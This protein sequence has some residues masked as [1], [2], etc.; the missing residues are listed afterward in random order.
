MAVEDKKVPGAQGSHFWPNVFDP[1]RDFGH[2][3]SNFFSPSADAS[4]SKDTYEIS[5]ELPGVE[6]KDIDISIHDNVLTIMGEKKFEQEKK[7]K[8]YYFSERRY[9]SFQR[10]FRLPP[11]IQQNDIDAHFKNGVLTVKIP[12]MLEQEP[13]RQKIDIRT[14]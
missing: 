5:M 8:D 2:A 11:G 14:E 13:E 12:K 9:G 6:E 3:V 4:N 1:L 7:E 10:S